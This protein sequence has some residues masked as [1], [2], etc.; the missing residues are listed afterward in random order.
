MLENY[1]DRAKDLMSDAQNILRRYKHSQL[2]TEHLLVAMLEDTDGIVTKLLGHLNTD[3]T[4]VKR[5]IET[6]LA[7][8][9][10]TQSSGGREQQIYITPRMKR[11]LDISESEA[12]RLRDEFVG[13]EHIFIAI[14]KE[15]DSASSRAL[16]AQ[17]VDLERVYQAL[18][19]LRKGT[20][21]DSPAAD[22]GNSIIGRY[23]RDL[24][25]L[26]KA[27][28]I[29]P[30]IGR[31]DEVDRVIQVLARRS[32]NNPVLIGD[33]GVGKT[34]IVEGLAQKIVDGAVPDALRGKTLLTLDLGALIAGA[35]FR[36][37]F[38]ERLK[39]VVDAVRDAAGQIILFIDELH[40]VVG[41]G[42]AEG[43]LDASNLLKPALARGELQC[44]GA[45]TIN[46]YRKYIEKD[47]ALERRFQ[48]VYVGEPTIVDTIAIIEGLRPKY[49]QHHQ[50][51]ITDEAIKAAVL[52]SSRY[53]TERFLP[54]KAIDLVDEAAS[55][56]RMSLSA[57]PV[58]LQ[59]MEKSLEDLLKRGK[60]AVDRMA[61][62]E[63]ARLR[64]EEAALRDTYSEHR[65]DWEDTTGAHRIVGEND[66]AGVVARITGVPIQRMLEEE[67]AKLL[68]LED[69]L[70]ERVIGQDRAITALAEAIRRSRV[71]LSDPKRPIGSFL[72]LGPTGVGKTEVA[73]GLAELLFDDEGALVRVDMS[74]YMEKH[75][76]ARLIGAPPGYVGHE[77]GGQLTEAVRKRPYRVVLL[78]EIEKA[79]PDVWNI[80]LQVLDDGRLTDG[81]GRVVSFRNTVI[82]MTSNLGSQEIQ[83]AIR[84][85][86]DP[87]KAALRALT[88]IIR[89][90]LINRIDEIIPFAGLT[91]NDLLKIVDLLLQRTI[92]A[93]LE[94][95]IT[96]SFTPEAKQSLVTLGFDP[97]Y[98]ARPLK[99]TIQR[100]V[101]NVLSTAILRG[102]VKPNDV[103]VFDVGADRPFEIH[104]QNR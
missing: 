64:D 36:G 23:T 29:D 62:E 73:K 53:I 2:D 14:I 100:Q 57:V 50:V 6:N 75:S 11:I 84:S 8:T 60:D 80:L 51:K 96:L 56:V 31:S 94:R 15:G 44:I 90:E 19:Q 92:S 65:R 49:E 52:L 91:E 1:T 39:G 27:G 102:D 45:T 59:Q 47:A 5:V 38:E 10:R 7:S 54:D 77:D 40:T 76:V 74:E 67:A 83:D 9:S 93:L 28:R 61:Y 101:D 12:Q 16:S 88:G 35:K 25:A 86:G 78:D 42:A 34:A 37:E 17:R 33:P 99:R 58:E 13:V 81:Q 63:A 87:E 20:R 82:L 103:V 18:A 72:F 69:R 3:I 104:I 24:T 48:P 68:H 4:A 97:V 98:G 26:A 70:H 66:I 79:H 46:E 89:P 43:S 30:V 32:K 41:A 55:K 85:G 22:V 71:G 95:S 21:S